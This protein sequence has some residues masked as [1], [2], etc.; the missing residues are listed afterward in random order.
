MK[1]RHLFCPLIPYSA[2]RRTSTD[3]SH[4]WSSSGHH[5]RHHR[6]LHHQGNKTLRAI[7]FSLRFLL[8]H[9]L[10]ASHPLVVSMH[11]TI[12]SVSHVT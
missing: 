10:F 4:N 7:T 3:A 9:T 1:V 5:H 6:R 11:H 8:F 2:D 12:I